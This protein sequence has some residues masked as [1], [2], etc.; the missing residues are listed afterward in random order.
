MGAPTCFAK[1]SG[2]ATTSS[3][4]A[5]TCTGSHRL[6]ERRGMRLPVKIDFLQV[7][8]LRRKPQFESIQAKVPICK[9]HSWVGTLLTQ[10]PE[11]LLGGFRLEE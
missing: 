3:M 6:I 2:L 7:P 10:K 4:S 9:M 8:I 1:S 11:Y 5:G